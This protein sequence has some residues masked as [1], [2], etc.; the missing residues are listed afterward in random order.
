MATTS[1][2]RN[3]NDANSD[4]SIVNTFVFLFSWLFLPFLFLVILFLLGRRLLLLLLL[5]LFSFL[6]LQRNWKTINRLANFDLYFAKNIIPPKSTET[7]TTSSSTTKSIFL[8]ADAADVFVVKLFFWS[9][10][11]AWSCLN[12]MFSFC[13]SGFRLSRAV[14]WSDR[15]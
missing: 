4:Y 3:N 12:L 15:L 8:V 7:F 10:F 14:C 5:W 9:F 11:E 13:N 2:S 1:D 6:P